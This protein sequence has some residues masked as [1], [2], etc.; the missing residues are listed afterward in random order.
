M[1]QDRS[2]RKAGVQLEFLIE[3]LEDR[4]YGF[5]RP[6]LVCKSLKSAVL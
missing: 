6:D 4:L 5:G 3:M 1:I 2:P